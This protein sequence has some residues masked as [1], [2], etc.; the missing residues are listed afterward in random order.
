[1]PEDVAVAWQVYHTAIVSRI[2]PLSDWTERW[3]EWQIG[4]VPFHGRVDCVDDQG[5]VRDTKPK[6]RRPTQDDINDSLQLTA[7]W[8]AVRQITG[9]APKAVA[10]DVLVRNKQPV[11]ETNLAGGSPKEVSR[12]T[13]IVL[14]VLEGADKSIIYPNWGVAM[15]CATC[16]FRERCITDNT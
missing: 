3:V 13:R 5:T 1:M 10:W 2:R 16:P 11:A 14:T 9:T 12:L 8:E 6:K 4:G 7:Y 15:G